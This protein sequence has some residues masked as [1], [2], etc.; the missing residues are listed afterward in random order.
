MSEI[1]M[2]VKNLMNEFLAEQKEQEARR[3]KENEEKLLV[4]G[5]DS[6]ARRPMRAKEV[7][8]YARAF[9]F[10][11]EDGRGRHGVHLVA[12][13]GSECPLP[14]HGGGRTLAIG[15]QHSIVSFIHVNGMG[16]K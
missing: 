1:P 13:N 3:S 11:V 12:P 7:Q 9:G 4:R 10:S 16:K 2:D 8:R 5:G 6:L 15:T 14:V